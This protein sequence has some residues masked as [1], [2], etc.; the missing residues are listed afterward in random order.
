MSQPTVSV[1]LDTRRE[2]K[3][4]LYPVKLRVYHRYKTRF[5]NTGIDT[6]ETN[7]QA[8]Y[9]TLRPKGSELRELKVRIASVEALANE[10]CAALKPFTFEKFEKQFLRPSGA[11]Q[12]IFHHYQEVIGRLK[13]EGRLG[14]ASNYDLSA[15]SISAFLFFKGRKKQAVTFEEVTVSFLHDYEK[16]MQST[17]KSITTIGIY[18]RPLRAVFNNAI[19]DGDIPADV[20]PF[21]KRK[22]QIPAGRNIKKALGKDSLKLLFEYPLSHNHFQEKARDFWFFSYVCNG[23]NIKDIVGLRY[24]NVTPDAIHFVRSKTRN[25]T[26]ADQKIITVPLTSFASQVIAK[27]GNSISGPETFVF[28]VLNET[29]S[30]EQKHSAVQAFTRFINQHVK[31]VAKQAG[32]DGAISTYWARH[33]FTTVSIQNGATMEFIQDSLG[34]NNI[35]TTMKYWKG[36]EVNTKKENANRLLDFT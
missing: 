21:G 36:F 16:W 14:T 23:M 17:G 28:P 20:Y 22:Y 35:A 27:Y 33:S 1:Y 9:G 8:S 10:I 12:D 4:V 6:T 30:E 18:L 34:H 3:D 25:T 11:G 31:I 29:M 15:K 26:R 2:K 5:Y 24:K 13:G 32:I 19:A 7:F